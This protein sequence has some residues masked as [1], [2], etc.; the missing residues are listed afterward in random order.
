[1]EARAAEVRV[2]GARAAEASQ[3]EKARVALLPVVLLLEPVP[4]L[5]APRAP[6]ILM[7]GGVVTLGLSKA[8]PLS[9]VVCL[10]VEHE[11][12]LDYLVAIDHT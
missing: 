9:L 6:Y 5:H 12:V 4:A 1:M 2:A 8:V 3:A 11:Y 10:V 7:P